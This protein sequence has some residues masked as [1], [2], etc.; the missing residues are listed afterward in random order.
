[1]KSIIELVYPAGR[2]CDMNLISKLFYTTQGILLLPVILVMVAV[3]FTLIKVTE[4]GLRKG[5][6]TGSRCMPIHERLQTNSDI[7]KEH[8]GI[9]VREL[10]ERIGNLRNVI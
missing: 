10:L 5:F 4:R 9:E 1:M 2:A 3:S 8:F 7:L 6:N